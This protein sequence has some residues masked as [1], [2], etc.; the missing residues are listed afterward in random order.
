MVGQGPAVTAKLWGVRC[1]D[2]ATGRGI[3]AVQVSI[4][5]YIAEW[6]DSAGWAAFAEPDFA[7]LRTSV[8]VKF[9]ADGFQPTGVHLNVTLGQ[10]VV[11]KLHR[12]ELAERLYRVTGASI[13]GSSERLGVPMSHIQKQGA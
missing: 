11:V 9:N 7:R 8:W 5:N 1:V 6:T 4:L 13:Y 12:V 10:S 2:D 3:P